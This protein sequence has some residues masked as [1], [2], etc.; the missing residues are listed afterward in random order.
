MPANEKLSIEVAFTGRFDECCHYSLSMFIFW[1]WQWIF[2]Q[3]ISSVRLCQRATIQSHN[4]RRATYWLEKQVCNFKLQFP[5]WLICWLGEYILVSNG[6]K[7]G[8]MPMGCLRPTHYGLAM[9]KPIYGVVLN[10]LRLTLSTDKTGGT[11]WTMV[12]P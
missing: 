7:M 8:G 3:V 9:D 10:G 5:W 6:V 11:I 4:I 2:D 12:G 1:F